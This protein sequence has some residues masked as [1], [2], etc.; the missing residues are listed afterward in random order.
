MR[1]SILALLALAL[2]GTLAQGGTHETAG[3]Q[4]EQ[5]FLDKDLSLPSL[6]RQPDGV[7][8]ANWVFTGSATVH[9][10][11]V[12]LN[13]PK[14]SV[15]D[16]AGIWSEKPLNH[17]AWT[18]EVT[19]RSLSESTAVT[20][21]T[22]GFS[23]WLIDDK[24]N[25]DE[26]LNGGPSQFDGLRLAVHHNSPEL[27]QGLTAHFGDG[28]KTVQPHFHQCQFPYQD[29]VGAPFTLRVSYS[30]AEQNWFKIQINN[31]LCLATTQ[32]IKLPKGLHLGA[33]ASQSKHK[34]NF[35]ILKMEVFSAVIEAAKDDHG[36]VDHNLNAPKV[37]KKIVQKTV[38]MD[39]TLPTG[40]AS[41][42]SDLLKL[43][44]I[45]SQLNKI[46]SVVDTK[47]G[48]DYTDVL[49][50]LARSVVQLQIDLELLKKSVETSREL[51]LA[52]ITKML[53]LV[54]LQHAE[55]SSLHLKLDTLLKSQTVLSESISTPVTENG[56]VDMLDYAVQTLKWFAIAIVVLFVVLG[57][58]IWR[59]K[60]DIVHGK[61][62]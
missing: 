62:L 56:G 29:Q 20:P 16:K 58:M 61:L 39:E 14:A 54:S 38:T 59:L 32:K 24:V 42:G 43:N 4:N 44:D 22:D 11:R 15:A 6:L 10:G 18:V 19:F 50:Q 3:H 31:K 27:Q 60:K 52:E 41:Q 2:R 51:V 13:D 5:K 47:P 1:F 12:L 21:A 8:P 17:D 55:L 37:V 23:L 35:E 7:P 46:Q 53:S 9:E 30:G 36:V 48:S 40:A 26:T 49:Q 57:V 25:N 34:E 33:S 45:M 28:S